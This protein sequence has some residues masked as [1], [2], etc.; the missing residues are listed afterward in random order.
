VQLYPRAA[1]AYASIGLTVNP[2]GLEFKS[3]LA[4]QAASDPGSVFVTGDVRNFELRA[5]DLPPLKVTLLNKA[6]ARIAQRVVTLPHPT[7]AA[8]QSE[9]FSV[10]LSDPKAQTANVYV[11]FALELIKPK[12]KLHRAVAYRAPAAARPTPGPVSPSGAA[13][14]PR[15][16]GDIGV[17]PLA[18]PPAAPGSPLSMRGPEAISKASHD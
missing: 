7:L 10:M 13:V 5:A 8:G 1:G 14:A 18:A 16:R 12:P 11:A 6:G 4:R 2:T 17:A 3:I 15:L 9:H